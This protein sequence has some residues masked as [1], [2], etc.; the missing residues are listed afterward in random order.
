MKDVI[1]TTTFSC[2]VVA[3]VSLA[4]RSSGVRMLRVSALLRLSAGSVSM[5]ASLQIWRS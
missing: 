4:R 5:G 1:D 2:R 3:A